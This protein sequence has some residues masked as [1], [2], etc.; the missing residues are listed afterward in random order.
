MI[1]EIF[2]INTLWQ[3]V[4]T[5]VLLIPIVTGLTSLVKPKFRDPANVPFASVAFGTVL[6]LLTV[7]LNVYGLLAGIIIGLSATGLYEAAFKK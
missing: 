4:S 5:A 3:Y 2:D 1:E 7:G 6:G